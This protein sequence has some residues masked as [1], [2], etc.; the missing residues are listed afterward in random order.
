M[1]LFGHHG[2]GSVDCEVL[3]TSI[4]PITRGFGAFRRAAM[5]VR[6]Y[7]TATVPAVLEQGLFFGGLGSLS[8]G[9]WMI[10][11]PLGPI[12]GGGLGVWVSFLISAER[13]GKR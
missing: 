6:K 13:A 7:V 10:Y 1:E 2:E 11:H 9:A 5:R 12:V 3:M 4:V 8:Y